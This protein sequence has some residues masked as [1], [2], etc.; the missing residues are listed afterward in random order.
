MAAGPFTLGDLAPHLDGASRRVV[1]RRLLQEGVLA[2][3]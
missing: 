3:A 1:A 2:R